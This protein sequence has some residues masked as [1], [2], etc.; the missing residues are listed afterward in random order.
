[1]VASAFLNSCAIPAESSPSAARFSLSCICCCSAASSVRSLSRQIAPLIFS[2]PFRI[3]EMVTP[4]W[5]RSP[6]GLACSTSSRRKTRPSLKHSA[7]NSASVSRTKIPPRQEEHHQAEQKNSDGRADSQGRQIRRL[8]CLQH[9][10][11]RE[12]IHIT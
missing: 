1:M 9:R 3:G 2:C 4:R 10:E 8:A 11:D 7:T 5:P 6:E 12:W